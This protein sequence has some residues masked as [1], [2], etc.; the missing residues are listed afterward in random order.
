M[1]Q[2]SPHGTMIGRIILGGAV[3]CGTGLFVASSVIADPDVPIPLGDPVVVD[4]HKGSDHCQIT[5]K[6]NKTLKEKPVGIVKV[7]CGRDS[8]SSENWKCQFRK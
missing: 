3:I 1:I 8:S 5:Q 2:R 4:C 6:D 7:E